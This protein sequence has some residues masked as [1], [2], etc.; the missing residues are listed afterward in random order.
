MNNNFYFN[1]LQYSILPMII[2]YLNF[3][4]FQ[5]CMW[6]ELVDDN[7][8]DQR[9]W[10]RAAAAAE[11]LWSNPKSSANF[12]R[13]RFYAHRE[14]LRKRNLHPEAVTPQWCVLNPGECNT[15]L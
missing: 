8:I 10:P 11:R 6:G 5:V 12:A 7:N 2:V 13:N 15:Y 1:I 14:R 4:M 3:P 9:I